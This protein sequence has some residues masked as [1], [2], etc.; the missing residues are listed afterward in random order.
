MRENGLYGIACLFRAD[1]LSAVIHIA[2]L[3]GLVENIAFLV[4]IH[5]L[6][7]LDGVAAQQILVLED[8][9]HVLFVDDVVLGQEGGFLAPVGFVQLGNILDDGDDISMRDRHP[10]LGIMCA[11]G[12]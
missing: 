8:D 10:A 9:G 4:E 3:D 7:P 2:S 11:H 5:D 12:I 6:F 1:Y